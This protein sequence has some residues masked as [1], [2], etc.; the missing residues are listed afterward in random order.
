MAYEALARPR[1][2]VHEERNNIPSCQMK[3]DRRQMRHVTVHIKKNK[4]RCAQ[5]REF[6]IVHALLNHTYC[7]CVMPPEGGG[8][9]ARFISINHQLKSP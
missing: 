2:D 4:T 3:K 6:N 1:C 5:R 8:E 9:E 7:C